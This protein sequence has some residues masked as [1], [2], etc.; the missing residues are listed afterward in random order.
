MH[1]ASAHTFEDIDL[2]FYHRINLKPRCDAIDI[3]YVTGDSVPIQAICKPFKLAIDQPDGWGD[4]FTV[5]EDRAEGPKI[6]LQNGVALAK[7][8]YALEINTASSAYVF[9]V[10]AAI[11]SCI[12]ALAFCFTDYLF[13]SESFDECKNTELGILTDNVE[14]LQERRAKRLGK[15]ITDA[16]ESID[17]FIEAYSRCRDLDALVLLWEDYWAGL[18]LK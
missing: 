10:D 4:Y 12:V 11:S 7:A 13:G 18:I 17:S 6:D 2:R 3:T 8:V 15:A 16:N 9:E 14:N 5:W 1:V